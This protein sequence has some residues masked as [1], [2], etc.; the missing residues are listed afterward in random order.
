[1]PVNVVTAAAKNAHRDAR[2]DRG[3]SPA[4]RLSDDGAAPASRW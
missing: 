4:H 3:A 1:V 2:D